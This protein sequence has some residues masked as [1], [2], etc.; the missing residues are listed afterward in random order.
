MAFVKEL[1]EAIGDQLESISISEG[2]KVEK[3]DVGET[4]AMFSTKNSRIIANLAK[5]VPEK[6]V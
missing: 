3:K 5:K 4:I 2:L 1:G 6:K